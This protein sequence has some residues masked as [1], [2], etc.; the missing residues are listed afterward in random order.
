MVINMFCCLNKYL[1][2]RF[3]KCCVRFCVGTVSEV[4]TI[5]YTYLQAQNFLLKTGEV[6]VFFVR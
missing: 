1:L 2:Q 4:I 6:L 5:L 3:A